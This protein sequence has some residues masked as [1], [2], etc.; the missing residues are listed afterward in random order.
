M[1]RSGSG[2]ELGINSWAG[3]RRATAWASLQGSGGEASAVKLDGL[4]G[5]IFHLV[6]RRGGHPPGEEV[7]EPRTE[8]LGGAT[9]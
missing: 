4:A 6:R 8:K 3:K 1:R 7:A 5:F 9:C 2:T